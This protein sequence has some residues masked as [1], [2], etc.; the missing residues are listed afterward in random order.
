MFLTNFYSDT[1]EKS[2]SWD[3]KNAYANI[4]EVFHNLS[5]SFTVILLSYL[6]FV[7]LQGLKKHIYFKS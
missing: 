2:T 3:S 4:S 5:V 7:H 1:S 6:G